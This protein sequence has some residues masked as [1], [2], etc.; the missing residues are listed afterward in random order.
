MKKILLIF[1]LFSSTAVQ[2]QIADNSFFPGMK[3]INPGISYLRTDGFISLDASREN[4]KKHHK[5]Q[6]GGLVDG[7]HYDVQVDKK[8]AYFAGRGGDFNLEILADQSEG[9]MKQSLEDLAGKVD[10]TTNAKA[11]YSGGLIDT[12]WVGV[13]MGKTSYNY[14]YFLETG[15]PPNYWARDNDWNIDF[16]VMKIGTAFRFGNIAIGAFYLSQSSD[17]VVDFTFFNPDTG[18]RGSTEPYDIDTETKGYGLGVGYSTDNIHIEISHEGITSQE[19]TKA[20]DF[21]WDVEKQ[22]LSSR[23][24]VVAELKLEWF[25]IG[26]RHRQIS[27]NFYDLEDVVTAKLL[28]EDLGSSDVRTDNTIN[29]SFGSKGFSVSG[30][31]SQSKTEFEE[32]NPKH[33]NGYL[34]P[35]TTDAQSMGVSIGY[36]Y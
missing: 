28:F 31:Y 15:S 25:A 10:Q 32:P 34:Y 18:G 4:I 23:M 36:I 21:P 7:I 29:F 12:K 33:D 11:N 20:A 9:T 16:R 24:S 1:I 6:L 2:A 26:V 22:P 19:L 27:G 3:T 30:F 5:S 17:G 14:H 35:A 13:L 8:T